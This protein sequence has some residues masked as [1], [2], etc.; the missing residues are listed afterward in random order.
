MRLA[1]PSSRA[2]RLHASALVTLI[3]PSSDIIALTPCLVT[4]CLCRRA[5][6]VQSLALHQSL[7][8]LVLHGDEVTISQVTQAISQLTRLTRLSISIYNAL[9]A[10]SMLRMA[11]GELLAPVAGCA[12]AA[13]R[14]STSLL[15]V[16][17][18]RA[19]SAPT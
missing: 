1:A 4:G 5:T 10:V 17:P 18:L 13:A 9:G 12:G 16:L 15:Q 19:K 3:E 6:D 14:G 11:L 7:E 8:E 2:T